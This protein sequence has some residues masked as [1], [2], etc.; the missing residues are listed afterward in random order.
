MFHH[1]CILLDENI[2][3]SREDE[4]SLIIHTSQEMTTHGNSALN[5]VCL[6]GCEDLEVT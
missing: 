2:E 6:S 5:T 3:L 1:N 4:I